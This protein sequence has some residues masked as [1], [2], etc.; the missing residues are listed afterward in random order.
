[1]IGIKQAYFRVKSMKWMMP[2]VDQQLKHNDCAISAIKTVC[3]ILN[4]PISR[5]VI[6]KSIHLDPDGA[7]FE[8]IQRFFDEQG[9]KATFQIL[10][11]NNWQ[12]L[13]NKMEEFVP[14]IALIKKENSNYL[15]YVVIS[16]VRSG[17]IHILDPACGRHE[18]WSLS[19]F[20]QKVHFAKTSL[21]S[22]PPIERIRNL[23]NQQLIDYSI[24]GHHQL[25]SKE[26]A[27]IY[28]KLT[29]FSYI[30]ENFAFKNNETERA[31]LLDLLQHQAIP[32]SFRNLK[33]VENR[34]EITAPV[35]LSIRH[36]VQQV[37]TK[38]KKDH[39]EQPSPLRRLIL[40][41][42]HLKQL[43]YI[44]I[45]SAILSSVATHLTVLINQ[46]LVD[47]ALPSYNLNILYTFAIG[48]LLFKLFDLGIE[49]Y[50]KLVGI[51]LGIELDRFFISK[52][53]EKVLNNSARYL[54]S[55]TKGDLIARVSDSLKIKRFFVQFFSNIFVNAIV[56]INSF[57]ILLFIDWKIS[58][59]VFAVML[60]FIILFCIVNSYVRKLETERFEKKATLFS[61][62]VES[63]QGIQTIRAFC[64]EN[65]LGRDIN[66][67]SNRFIEIQKKGK[68]LSLINATVVTFIS[69]ATF[70]AL[71]VICGRK[72]MLDQTMSL[73]QFL[74]FLALSAKILSSLKRLLEENLDLQENLVILKRYFDFGEEGQPSF[75]KQGI[76]DVDI[77]KLETKRVGFEYSP[78]NSILQ[79]INL[80][81]KKGEK[82]LLT[83]ANGSGKSTLAKILASIYQPTLGEVLINGINREFYD[84]YKLRRKVVLVGADDILFNNTLRFNIT[85][86][87]RKSSSKIVKYAKKIG[88]YDL[89]V[90]HPD[91][92]DWLIE[93][94]GQ[95]LSTGQRQKILVLRALL[96]DADVLIFDEI[97]RGIDQ[98]SKLAIETL[99]N[100][101]ND[102]AMLFISHDK[103]NVLSIDKELTISNGML[104]E[105]AEICTVSD[106]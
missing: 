70:L 68:Y 21:V 51:H 86:G 22:L 83:G 7:H 59:L 32:G 56:S 26:I 96:S 105:K 103:P 53:H 91:K 37:I 52:F 61:K 24:N 79:Q 15:H 44:F 57:T 28:N 25:T 47:E 17:K 6:E 62:L 35:V 29:Y 64:L 55:F 42:G 13:E 10:D 71:V 58:L 3:N 73:G 40:D 11:I 31:F 19:E 63:V 16:R 69:H 104:M 34:L 49:A 1:M 66:A 99:L 89:I 75:D 8:A 9:F 72:L 4:F 80:Q 106:L 100:E 50:T 95:N 14:L 81:I 93:E 98:K 27:G 48:L 33:L 97:F 84:E 54:Y 20:R 92:L 65:Y 88:L 36:E 76:R 77:K 5:K 78:G 43:W 45:F 94:G 46:I 41:I 60:S 85:L 39:A 101:I 90:E 23:V 82:I 18:K 74:T 30:K 67:E 102:Q 12:E 87:R 2:K 38:S